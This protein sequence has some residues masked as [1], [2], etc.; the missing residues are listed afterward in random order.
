MLLSLVLLLLLLLLAVLVLVEV[1]VASSSSSVI[2]IIIQILIYLSRP[3]THIPTII[4]ATKY[5]TIIRISGH[6]IED[7]LKNL[8]GDYN[9]HNPLKHNHLFI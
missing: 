5:K 2:F 3:L 8:E 9:V 6:S 4:I 7:M 1:L